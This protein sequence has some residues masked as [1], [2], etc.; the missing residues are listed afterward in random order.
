MLGGI[1]PLMMSLSE[2]VQVDEITTSPGSWQTITKP[3]GALSCTIEAIGASGGSLFVYEYSYGSAG[4]NFARTN[5]V[6]V[7]SATGLAVNVGAGGPTDNS[8]RGGQTII[9]LNSSSG[10]I[11]CLAA[12]SMNANFN[13]VAVLNGDVGDVVNLGESGINT[14]ATAYGGAAAGPGGIGVTPAGSR[15]TAAG[16]PYGGGAGG[17]RVRNVGAQGWARLTWRF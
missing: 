4:G 3:D 11:V 8:T 6:D 15:S 14:Q 17:Y 2:R 5:S 7:T 13:Q 16:L 1:N 10:T 9:R 12:G